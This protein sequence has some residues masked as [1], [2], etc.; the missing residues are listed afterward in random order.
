MCAGGI[1]MLVVTNPKL[2]LWVL[3]VVPVVVAPIIIFGR[4]VRALSREAQARVAD[5]VSEGGA[6][7]DAVRT[8]QAFAQ[9]TPAAESFGHATER[10]FRAAISHISRRAIESTLVIL[11]LFAGV[12]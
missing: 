6:T 12:R 7:L 10:A 5:M 9:V 8:V 4:R 2:A 3:A 11:H 1:I